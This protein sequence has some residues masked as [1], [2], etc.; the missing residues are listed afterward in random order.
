MPDIAEALEVGLNANRESTD[1]DKFDD[2]QELFGNTYCPGTS[3]YCSYGAL[4][5]NEDWGVI[6]AEM[7][8][9][10][11]AP[12]HHPLVAGFPVPEV[13]VVASSFRV[14][15]V[16]TVTTAN[17]TMTEQTQ[18]YSTA[19]TEGT[20]TS[21]ADTKTWNNWVEVSDSTTSIGAQSSAEVYAS[22]HDGCTHVCG[23][24]RHCDCRV[25]DWHRSIGLH[26]RGSH[27][28][29]CSPMRWVNWWRNGRSLSIR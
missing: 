25:W 4:P 11:K 12:G 7:P 18:S 3:G 15:L 1:R 10:V 20:S 26:S 6:F 16:T 29:W 17:G 8:A 21:V 27:T 22:A 9:W 14:E 19:K 13:D 2:G 24:R 28:A 5:R 23:F